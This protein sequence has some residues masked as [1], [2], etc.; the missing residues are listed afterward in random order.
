M[1]YADLGEIY[2]GLERMAGYETISAFSLAYYELIADYLASEGRGAQRLRVCFLEFMEILE[3]YH[4]ALEGL[5]AADEVTWGNM[6]SATEKRDIAL[7]V[8]LEQL[9]TEV[10]AGGAEVG[11]LLLVAECQYQIGA[12]ASVVDRLEAAVEMGA[13]HPLVLFALGYN[14]YALAMRAFTR[15]SS[16]DGQREIAD[17]DRFRLAC[18]S[19][20][21]AFQDA[22]TGTSFDG[23]L[24]WWIGSVLSAA[25]FADAAQ[26]SFDK[27]ESLL[28]GGGAW[29]LQEELE[30]E[31]H[32][33]AAPRGAVPEGPITDD[34]VREAGILLRRSYEASDLLDV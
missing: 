14:R 9:G 8:L 1:D 19:A 25:G 28:G 6:R 34:E 13:D 3:R 32:H 21:S 12:V 24:H 15:Y 5:A 29:G 17:A 16:V 22:L 2:E 33:L 7:R 10:A 11:R 27:A 23:H 30:I 31:P 18:L 4:R 20:V 26:A